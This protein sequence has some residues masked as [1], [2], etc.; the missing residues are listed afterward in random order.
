MPNDE[1]ICPLMKGECIK[2][3]CKWY[4]DWQGTMRFTCLFEA[5]LGRLKWIENALTNLPRAISRPL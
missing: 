5:L 3:K 4:A 1:K 2:E